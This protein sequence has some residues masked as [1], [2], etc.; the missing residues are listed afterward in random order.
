MPA[1][2]IDVDAAE[3]DNLESWSAARRDISNIL[4]HR[5]Y[6]NLEVE[7]QDP[8]RFYKPSLF[9]IHPTHAAVGVYKAARIELLTQIFNTIGMVWR[10]LSLFEVGRTAKARKPTVVLMVEPLATH[11]WKMLIG[12]LEAVLDKYRGNLPKLSVEVM[13][14]AVNPTPPQ[15]ETKE[16]AKGLPGLPFIHDFNTHPRNGTSIGVQGEIGGGTLGGFFKMVAPSR[17]H[18]GFLTNSH[19]VAPPTNAP[20][21]ERSHYNIMGLP[22]HGSGGAGTRIHYFA[23]ND[24][25]A[26]KKAGKKAI[27][28]AED[29]IQEQMDKEK[30][31]SDRGRANEQTR[32]MLRNLIRTQEQNIQRFKENI[33]QT[34]EMPQLYGRT[35]LASGRA[36]N[37]KYMTLD[38]AFVET[39]A[40]SSFRSPCFILQ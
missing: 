13:P 8:Q 3:G 1:L 32:S 6:L 33:A 26:T 4:E 24:V 14:G 11:D 16:Q 23:A 27:Q 38:Y 18:I 9:A 17:T 5:G 40:V 21:S 15:S 10:M 19:V 35:I 30:Q 34:K 22:Y 20:S 25:K 37:N 28:V 7:I 36:L 2:Y 39:S 12:S 29:I 31:R